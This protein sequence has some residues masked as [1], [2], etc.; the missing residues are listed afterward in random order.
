MLAG[1]KPAVEFDRC[2]LSVYRSRLSRVY[3]SR[4]A[5]WLMGRPKFV[6]AKIQGDVVAL[7]PAGQGAGLPVRFTPAGQPY[8]VCRELGK[9]IG[10]DNR[11][12]YDYDEQV[13]ERGRFGA[14]VFYFKKK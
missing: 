3:L 12:V 1:W 14:R 11:A 10:P 4:E 9:A 2:Y 13:R 7:S 5:Y 6:A 8:V